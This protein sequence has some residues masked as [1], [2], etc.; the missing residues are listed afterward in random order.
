MRQT[1]CYSTHGNLVGQESSTNRG[2]AP[3]P[4]FWETYTPRNIVAEIKYRISNLAQHRVRPQ[5][6]P[7]TPYDPAHARQVGEFY[8]A[9]H[10]DFMQVYGDVIQAFRTRD[11]ADLLNY[12]IQ[13]IGF[14][15]GQRVLDAGCGIAAPAIHFASR[16]GVFV[17]GITISNAQYEAA[18][19]RIA[20]AGLGERVRVTL[21]DYHALPEHF[22]PLAY[23]IVYFLE[24]FGHSRHKRR[25]IEAA[26]EVLKPGG[27]LYI[28][29]LFRRVPL[30][31]E[32]R[33][34]IDRE[35]R[36]INEAY[37]YDVGD[38]NTV[39]EDI[40]RKGFILTSLRAMELQL[41]Q[42]EDLAISNVFQE[43]TGLARIENWSEYV[44]PVD[45]FEIQCVK[46]E[47]SLDQRLDRHFLQNRYHLH[48]EAQAKASPAPSPSDGPRSSTA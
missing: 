36:R 39:L 30:R 25:L 26:W 45:F 18:R 32:H 42:F 8:D 28:K 43:L 41:D 37:H 9:R 20:A 22:A 10:Q 17:D 15:P 46:P 38:L 47:F 14:E 44:F 31:L 5:P 21:G 33:E 7:A 40:R 1:G 29:D 23:D 6:E 19:Q 35:I 48:L 24:S 11:I 16:A 13:S 34:P 4:T 27:R 2:P 12:Q 3:Q